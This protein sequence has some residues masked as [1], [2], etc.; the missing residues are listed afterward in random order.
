MAAILLD[1]ESRAVV[2]DADPSHGALKEPILFL[3]GF[4]RSM[5]FEANPGHELIK[6]HGVQ[7]RI[8]QM[9]FESPTVFSFMLPHYSPFGPLADASLVAPEAQLMAMSSVVASMNAM[10]SLVNFGLT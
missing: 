4:M 10:F 3:L 5:Q 7:D 2:L 1:R 8:G 6:L 9:A